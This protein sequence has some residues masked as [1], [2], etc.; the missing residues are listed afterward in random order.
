MG[1]G[2]EMRILDSW[3]RSSSCLLRFDVWPAKADPLQSTQTSGSDCD[4][5]A[6]AST[7]NAP[8]YEPMFFCGQIA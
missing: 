2:I 4:A 7:H 5:D 6:K 1:D 8:F 3:K